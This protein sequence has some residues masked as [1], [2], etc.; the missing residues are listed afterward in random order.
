MESANFHLQAVS[1]RCCFSRP[2]PE[3]WPRSV[4]ELSCYNAR[5]D[6]VHSLIEVYDMLA[7]HLEAWTDQWEQQ[8]LVRGLEQ[9][10]EQGREAARC[11]PWR[12]KIQAK[13]DSRG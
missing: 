12:A 8:G 3:V 6:P 2:N 7:E 11:R 5:P 4:Q 13:A 1:R 10:L 9:G